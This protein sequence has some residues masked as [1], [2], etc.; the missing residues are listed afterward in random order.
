MICPR[1]VA[2]AGLVAVGWPYQKPVHRTAV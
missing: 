2:G 1:V